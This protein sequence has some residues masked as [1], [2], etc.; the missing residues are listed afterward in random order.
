MIESEINYIITTK[1]TV[2]N[3]AD[4]NNFPKCT[5]MFKNSFLS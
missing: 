3:M 2:K 4:K 5:G 1:H